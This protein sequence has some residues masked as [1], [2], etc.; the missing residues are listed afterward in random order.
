MSEEEAQ[1]KPER[2]KKKK[3]GDSKT[4]KG[5]KMWIEKKKQKNSESSSSTQIATSDLE[6]GDTD[7]Y[8]EDFHEYS[9]PEQDEYDLLSSGFNVGMSGVFVSVYLASLPIRILEE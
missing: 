1:E 8:D 2:K 5:R 9:D 7:D 4:G 3:P 6:V